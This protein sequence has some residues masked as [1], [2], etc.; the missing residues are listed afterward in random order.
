MLWQFFLTRLRARP[1]AKFSTAALVLDGIFGK[2][3]RRATVAFQLRFNLRPD[4]VVGPK[5]YGAARELGF[6]K[7]RVEGHLAPFLGPFANPIGSSPPPML[8][9]PEGAAAPA[10][11]PGSKNTRGVSWRRLRAESWTTLPGVM[12]GLTGSNSVFQLLRDGA[13][14]YIY[15][16]YSVVVEVMP[17][18]KTAEQFLADMAMDLN[19]TINNPDFD[20][21]NVFR[22]RR[23]GSPEVGEIIDIDILGPEN[24]SVMLVERAPDHFV[25]QTVDCEPYGSHPENGSREFGFERLGGGRFRFYTRGVSRPGNFITRLAGAI[26]QR[27]GWTNLMLG[28]AAGINRL[29]GRSPGQVRIAKENR[30]E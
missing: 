27:K 9:S 22:R 15:D 19:G 18:D 11:A 7:D 14:D 29:G 23:K 2:E 28:I 3:T 10:P 21:I 25:F 20:T 6:G 26:P 1:D 5:T 4:G 17:A 8:A 13:G 16:E 12:K 30:P 24:G